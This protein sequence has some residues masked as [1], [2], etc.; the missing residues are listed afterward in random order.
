MSNGASLAGP[1]TGT[2]QKNVF[3][4]VLMVAHADVGEV[5][6][7]RNDI[8]CRC[9]CKAES[10]VYGAASYCPDLVKYSHCSGDDYL[11]SLL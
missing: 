9:S 11:V 4:S 3:I 5:E 1:E 10:C 7:E 6:L 2:N 8:S